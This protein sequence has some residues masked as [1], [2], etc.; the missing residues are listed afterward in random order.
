MT[1][2]ELLIYIQEI[3]N[4]MIRVSTGD[5][6]DDEV[7]KDYK[8]IF[9]R[10]ESALK[11]R[12]ANH[13]NKFSSLEEFYKYWSENLPS[14][15]D[16]RY[17]VHNLYKDIEKKL[18]SSIAG[19]KVTEDY[20]MGFDDLHEEIII[21]CKEDFE[22]EKY[23]NAVFAA[24]RLLEIKVREKGGF[25][26]ADIGRRLM[27]K[28]FNPE[29]TPFDLDKERGEIVGLLEL[30]KGAI[31][32]FKNPSSHREIKRGEKEAFEIL[33]FVSHLLSIL[34]NLKIK[35]RKVEGA[36]EEIPF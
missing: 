17:Y 6:F 7:D 4:L 35:E 2:K 8:S 36:E 34:D 29:I 27:E 26:Q 18:Y 19:E 16:R 23:G 12:K 10:I 9:F 21:K 32:V 15:R 20:F 31:G 13:K 1:N 5:F 3:Q 33:C 30:F 11:A 22:N 25:T 24:T 28:A 14:Y